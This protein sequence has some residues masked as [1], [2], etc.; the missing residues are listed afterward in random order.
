VHDQDHLD[1]FARFYEREA[2][3]LIRTVAVVTGEPALA[4]DAVAEAFARAWLRWPRLRSDPRPAVPWLLQ[5]ALNECRGR[6]RRHKLERRKAHLVARADAVDDP[7][8][9][10]MHVWAAVAELPEPDRTLIALRYVA[11][12]TQEQIA[13]ALD[14]PSGTV[15]SGLHRARRRLGLDLGPSYEEMSHG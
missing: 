8:P 10:T 1:D 7:E 2:Q 12:L 9:M 3:R 5:V 14:L 6:F 13:Q 4:E 11:D 15:A